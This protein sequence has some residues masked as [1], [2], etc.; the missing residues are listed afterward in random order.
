MKNVST[1]QLNRSQL[2]ILL[3]EE[4]VG[5]GLLLLALLSPRIPEIFCL[6]ITQITKLYKFKGV[7]RKKK[8]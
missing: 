6:Q 2:T 1:K 7:K 3:V 8:K 5:L 4:K